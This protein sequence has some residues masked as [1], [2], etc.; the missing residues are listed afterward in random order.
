MTHLVVV[1]HEEQHSVWPEAR[2][3]PA[4][5]NATGFNGTRDECLEH[6]ALVWTDIRP[7]SARSEIR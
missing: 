1:N 2:A 4:G 3:L 7:A 6:I 5:W